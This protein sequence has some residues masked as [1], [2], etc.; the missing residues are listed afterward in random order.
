MDERP[1]RRLCYSCNTNF[2][3]FT[4]ISL[5]FVQFKEAVTENQ[6]STI[7]VVFKN[8]IRRKNL[9]YFFKYMLQLI[10]INSLNQGFTMCH[11][12]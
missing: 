12:M 11:L 8:C 10:A 2:G 3:Y 7:S 4:L 6:I 5:S 1:D 9:R